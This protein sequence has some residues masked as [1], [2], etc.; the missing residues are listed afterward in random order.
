MGILIV[1]LG[2]LQTIP[3]IAQLITPKVTISVTWKSG[4]EVETWPPGGNQ[5]PRFYLR[6]NSKVSAKDPW[7]ILDLPQNLGI[8]A[9]DNTRTHEVEYRHEEKKRKAI[10]KANVLP[11]HTKEERNLG[12]IRRKPGKYIIK[13][14]ITGTNVRQKSGNL[15]LVI[16]KKK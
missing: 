13:Y 5:I 7:V 16:G 11:P 8:E 12:F 2:I 6:N 1:V 9:S 3:G 4:G 15:V 14:E 10:L